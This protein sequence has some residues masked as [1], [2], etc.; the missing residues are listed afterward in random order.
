M[1]LVIMGAGYVGLTAAVCFAEM[2]NDVVCIEV[3]PEKLALLKAS[4]LPI[5]EPYLDTLFQHNVSEAR[6]RF[7]ASLDEVD[8]AVDV[9]FICVGTPARPSGE[10]NLDYV[11]QAAQSIASHVQQPAV[12]VTKSTV[13]VG[14]GD[15]IETV[16]RST[17]SN[18]LQEQVTVVSNPEFMKEGVAIDDFMSPDRIL[19][20]LNDTMALPVLQQ[21]YA[22][23]TRKS[24]RIIT[25]ARRDAEMTK[26][27]A[28]AML[29]NRISFMN[30]MALICDQWGADIESVRKGI[31]SD[32]RIGEYF[33]YAG[34]GF[35][36]S[37]FPKDVS[38]LKTMAQQ[39]S[40]DP[41]MLQAIEARNAAQKRY[42][43]DKLQQH[44]GATLPG[45]R[46]AVWGLSFKPKTDDVRDST[47]LAMIA[48]A[49]DHGMTVT[50]YDPVAMDAF[51]AAV[52]PAWIQQGQL[53]LCDEQYQALE[54]AD[55][56]ALLTEWKQFRQPDFQRMQALL[57]HPVIL[58][59]RNQYDS[60]LLQSEGFTYF[61]IGRG[62]DSGVSSVQIADA[63][64]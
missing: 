15:Q 53:I 47:A 24:D 12:V 61:G 3:N 8:A 37:C 32:R 62:R 28:N 63:T 42:L 22:P 35:G 33:L 31:G 34:C 56:F 10:C 6:L 48:K 19:L 44:Y 23:F 40:I 16:L 20:G 25:M 45:R 7:A 1:K 36:G 39:Q 46:L 2:G 5:F 9:Y 51:R 13:P 54:G 64:A 60:R 30:E 50:A 14:T 4:Q 17:L 52:P 21:L 18:A 49:I 57:K 55:A 27:V 59:G 29:A 38:A 41:L 58:D 43:F 26:Y 11:M